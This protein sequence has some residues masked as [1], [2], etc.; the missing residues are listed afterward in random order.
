MKRPSG[1]FIV[2]MCFLVGG[3][4]I[5]YSYVVIGETFFSPWARLPKT[6]TEVHTRKPDIGINTP[7]IMKARL[8]KVEFLNYAEQEGLLLGTQ[9]DL[10][11]LLREAMTVMPLVSGPVWWNPPRNPDLIAYEE[12]EFGMTVI[13]YKDGWMFYQS[14]MFPR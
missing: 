1:D 3:P 11:R 6:A 9:V 13:I 5:L 10:E 2:W 7:V 4:I 14:G 8:R 12:D